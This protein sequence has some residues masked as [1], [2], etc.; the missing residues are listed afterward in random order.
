M[1]KLADISAFES[2]QR[3]ANAVPDMAVFNA[4]DDAVKYFNGHVNGSGSIISVLKRRF[5]KMT[6]DGESLSPASVASKRAWG[7]LCQWNTLE[8]DC[9]D[10]AISDLCDE[11]E[12]DTDITVNDLTT[13]LTTELGGDVQAMIDAT[14]SSGTVQDWL[15]RIAK[16]LMRNAERELADREE[17]GDEDEGKD[18]DLSE[19]ASRAGMKRN[20]DI[21][22]LWDREIR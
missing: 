18:E 2:L 3:S 9:V 8:M 20:V 17:Y 7:R 16:L 12:V 14:G 10:S 21:K 22:G 11:L 19:Y 15:G 13:V 5:A 1:K 6:R 4:V